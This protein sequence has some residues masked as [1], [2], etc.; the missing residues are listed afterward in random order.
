M[1]RRQGDASQLM[2]RT[3]SNVKIAE[4]PIFLLIDLLGAEY[5]DIKIKALSE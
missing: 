2:L 4:Q 1:T 3:L 5:C